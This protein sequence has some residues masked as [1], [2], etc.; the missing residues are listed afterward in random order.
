MADTTPATIEL[1]WSDPRHAP[2]SVG[3]QAAD[4]L[5]RVLGR[6]GLGGAWVLKSITRS[7]MRGEVVFRYRGPTDNGCLRVCIKPGDNG[8][9]YEY[10]V[11][12]PADAA[13][14]AVQ[15]FT[16]ADGWNGRDTIGRDLGQ[17]PETAGPRDALGSTDLA[18]VL[19]AAKARRDKGREL[20]ALREELVMVETEL[21]RLRGEFPKLESEV[22]RLA[23]GIEEGER[24]L[25]RHAPML[26]IIEDL[27]ELLRD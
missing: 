2:I 14:Q 4:L 3:H 7:T 16:D 22:A 24:E 6:Y 1:N 9:A 8:T 11:R 26:A 12:G 20:A 25:A 10:L 5:K 19:K 21:Q 13:I 23:R 27:R 17:S 15:A 18:E